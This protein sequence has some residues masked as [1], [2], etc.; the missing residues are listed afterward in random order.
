MTT[1]FP[2][3]RPRGRRSNC[4]V[5]AS[6]K[7]RNHNIPSRFVNDGTASSFRARFRDLKRVFRERYMPMYVL[8]DSFVNA[9]VIWDIA[10]RSKEYITTHL[11][12]VAEFVMSFA[13]WRQS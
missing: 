4:P 10:G 5:A 8:W 3:R 9:W 2:T 7:N 11:R 13:F 12:I 1:L 6:R